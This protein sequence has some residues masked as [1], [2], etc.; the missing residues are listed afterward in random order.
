MSIRY[1]IKLILFFIFFFISKYN[2]TQTNCEKTIIEVQNVISKIIERENIINAEYDSLEITGILKIHV[3]FVFDTK[4]NVINTRI[5]QIESNNISKIQKKEFYVYAINLL[6][7][8]K[9]IEPCSEYIH[10]VLP[11]TFIS[12]D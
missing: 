9:G 1:S 5:K 10:F 6:N 3:K 12:L 4:G 11:V 2:F 7:E 8:L